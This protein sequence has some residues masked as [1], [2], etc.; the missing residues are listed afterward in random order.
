MSISFISFAHL[1]AFA[2][3]FDRHRD[4]TALREDDE[5]RGG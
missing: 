3:D 5:W 1:S 4:M 2:A